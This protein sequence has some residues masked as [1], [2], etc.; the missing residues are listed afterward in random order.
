MVDC[1]SECEKISKWVQ[2]YWRVS[3]LQV[4]ER[5]N[6]NIHTRYIIEKGFDTVSRSAYFFSAYSTCLENDI[7]L[8]AKEDELGRK[9]QASRLVVKQRAPK[10]KVKE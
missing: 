1:F 5:A 3:S 10:R 9:L 4:T 8:I 2:L 6:K 7:L